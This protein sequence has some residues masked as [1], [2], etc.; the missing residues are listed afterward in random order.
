MNKTR[1][2]Q[3]D[4]SCREKTLDREFACAKITANS[5]TTAIPSDWKDAN[6]KL[7]PLRQ[8]VLNYAIH[9]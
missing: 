2:T 5:A 9:D 4:F 8:W 3:L 1:W 6:D 7:M